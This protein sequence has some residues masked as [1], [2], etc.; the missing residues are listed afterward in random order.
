MQTK[1]LQVDSACP[2]QACIEQ[3]ASIVEEGGLVAFPTETVY[4]IACRVG[5]EPLEKLNRLKD[6]V[7]EKHYTLHIGD[8]NDVNRYVPSL[9]LRAQ[10]LIDKAWPGPLTIVFELKDTDIEKQCKSLSR[11]VFENLYR[12]NSIGIRCPDNIVALS[13]LKQAKVPVVAPSAN[14]SGRSPAVNA[15]QVIEQLD[16]MIDLVL[17]A[18]PC[19]YSQ[20]STV[21]K[22]G[23]KGI[24]ILRHGSYSR[25][26]IQDQATVNF[27]FVCTGNTCRSPMA[28]GLFKKY[29]AEKLG[30]GVDQLEKMGYKVLSAGTLG[31][32]GLPASPESVAACEAKG[33]DIRSHRSRALTE[34][35]VDQSDHIFAMSTGHRDR[36]VGLCFGSAFRCR[37]LINNSNVPDPIGQSQQVYN[38]CADMI[39]EAVKKLVRELKI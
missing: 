36:I 29:L 7:S 18:G 32:A 24:E 37:L 27:L 6:R 4:G 28:E 25:D 1:I 22:I 20:N 38:E 16:G 35:L 13:M 15:Q 31:I 2:D 3:A 9:G 11:D 5:I 19:K 30:C 12:D 39:E 26:R 14:L 34:Q 10:K 21:V 23:N 33:V 8:I 17:D